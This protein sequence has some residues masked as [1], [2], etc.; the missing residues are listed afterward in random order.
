MYYLNFLTQVH[1]R[2]QPRN[3]LEVGIRNGGSLAL[4]RCRSVAIDP[5]YSITA[6]L[7]APVSL[8]R[9]SS[10]EYFSREDPLL[11]TGGQPF[12]LAFID[13]LHLFEFAL[14]DLINAERHA[15]SRSM[16]I[17]DDV[18]PRTIDEA[19]RV[20][21]T[22]AWT[23]D[24]YSILGVIAKYRPELSVITIGTLPTGLL[25]ITGLD[26]SST[27]LSDH[28]TEILEEFRHPDPQPVPQ[29]VLDRLTIASPEK[30][31]DS[32]LLE[33][34]AEADPSITPDELRPRL[35]SLIES[36]LGRAYAPGRGIAS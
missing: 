26:P 36:T 8:F 16:I 4:S 19:A 17:F 20:R 14:R 18:L 1:E 29:Y 12:D 9:T 5:A 3:Y 24:V 28:Y 25:M 6:E 21:H 27:V 15:S 30:V 34:L 35:T 33:L 2:L 10:D 13:G 31:L 11:P 32:G 22:T 23:G 7:N